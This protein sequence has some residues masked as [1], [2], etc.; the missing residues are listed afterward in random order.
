MLL[1]M[2]DPEIR[3]RLGQQARLTAVDHTWEVTTDVYEQVCR[4]IA[5]AKRSRDNNRSA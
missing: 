2:K 4:Q 5:A 1:R 3:H